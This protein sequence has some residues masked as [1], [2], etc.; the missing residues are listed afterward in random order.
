MRPL[1]VL[2]WHIHGSY[3]YYLSQTPVE[4]YLPVK[5]DVPRINLPTHDFHSFQLR[6]RPR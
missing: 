1:R 4:F 6:Y 5:P 3:L 2:T